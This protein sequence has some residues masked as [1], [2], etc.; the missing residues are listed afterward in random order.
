MG[1]DDVARPFSLPPSLPLLPPPSL[2]QSGAA[3]S[4]EMAHLA[5][6]VCGAAAQ[7]VRSEIH[8]LG[9][10]TYHLKYVPLAAGAKA[11]SVLRPRRS[12]TVA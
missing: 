11:Q 3:L 6:T 7:V 2:P 8:D 4:S 5:P 1:G 10:G 9:D 12:H